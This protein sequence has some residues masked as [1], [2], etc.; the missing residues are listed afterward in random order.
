MRAATVLQNALQIQLLIGGMRA[1]S[2]I[3]SAFSY[4]GGLADGAI[5]FLAWFSPLKKHFREPL[6]ERLT[7]DPEPRIN[8]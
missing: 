4:L 3:S 6:P 5:L 1:S 8:S 2:P 7:A